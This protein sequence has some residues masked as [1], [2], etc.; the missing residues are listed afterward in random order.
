MKVKNKAKPGVNV[1]E[2][3]ENAKQYL[4][5]SIASG[6]IFTTLVLVSLYHRFLKNDYFPFM[7]TYEFLTSKTLLSSILKSFLN[8]DLVLRQGFQIQNNAVLVL[9]ISIS[10]FATMFFASLLMSRFLKN[11]SKKSFLLVS[12]GLPFAMFSNP[13]IAK[14]F[15]SLNAWIV[16]IPLTMLA[17][18]MLTL[19]KPVFQIIGL[20][21]LALNPC[22]YNARE[23]LLFF[24]ASMLIASVLLKSLE[25]FILLMLLSML[26]NIAV[27]IELQGVTNFNIASVT[28]L[29]KVN[30]FSSIARFFAETGSKDSLVLL[31]VLLSFIT[32]S[33][34]KPKPFRALT[35]ALFVSS[36]AIAD[37]ALL[38]VLSFTASTLAVVA[39]ALLWFKP[40]SFDLLKQASVFITGLVALYFL[41]SNASMIASAEPSQDLLNALNIVKQLQVKTNNAKLLVLQDLKPL[42]KFLNISTLAVSSQEFVKTPLMQRDFK[43][44]RE[45]LD[46]QHVSFVLVENNELWRDSGFMFLQTHMA[47]CNLL[48]KS[49]DDRIKLYNC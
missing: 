30:N 46:S 37:K 11:N 27:N 47:M 16:A 14:T 28:P 49:G 43:T 20:L 15:T 12:I 5:V 40:W 2:S 24:I 18:W 33:N 19:K 42:T 9:M 31:F 17:F 39:V 32:I 29:L 10:S 44:L 8:S 25:T 45:W 38:L 7:N 3:E 35:M 26:L 4:V 23:G 41:I 48:F 13:L 36:F 22:L 21:I 34:F 6:L 1:K